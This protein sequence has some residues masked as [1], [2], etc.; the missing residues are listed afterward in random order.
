MKM[1]TMCVS[2][3]SAAMFVSQASAQVVIENVFDYTGGGSAPDAVEASAVVGL[4]VTETG[5][6]GDGWDTTVSIPIT[7]NYSLSAD[8][9]GSGTYTIEGDVRALGTAVAG[10]VTS[11]RVFDDVQ[12]AAGR[13]YELTLGVG[14]SAFVSLLGST[15][16]SL[17]VRDGV[18]GIVSDLG[19]VTDGHGLLGAVDLLGLFGTGDSTTT[20]NFDGVAFDT[21][22]DLVVTLQTGTL[23]SVNDF[24]VSFNELSIVD[25][26]PVPEPSSVALL[27]LGGIALILRR[28]K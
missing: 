11:T 8:M 1:K 13:V 20:V 6:L 25:V 4:A 3:A 18:S 24:V 23:A 10:S 27:G 9:P 21:G 16:I 2:L 7:V 28:R 26:T 14:N 15:S 22:D 17:G 12:L 19:I 5:N